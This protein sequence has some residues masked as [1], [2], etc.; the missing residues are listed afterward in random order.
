MDVG[1]G[2]FVFSHGLLD[3]A[4]EGRTTLAWKKVIPLVV[5][6]FIRLISVKAS[7]YHEHV[8]EYGV[9]W[10]FFFTL[11]VVNF[12]SQATL[13]RRIAPWQ[14]STSI[15]IAYHLLLKLGLES[16][17]MGPSERSGL[18]VANR[19]GVFSLFGYI[20]IY[21]AASQLGGEVLKPRNCFK[22]RL[23]LSYFDLVL[24]HFK[25][26]EIQK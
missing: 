10:N 8:T 22:D 9:H 13:L 7:G 26:Y 15:L 20:A 18:L 21:F 4:G 2:S 24:L 17:I 1:V 14:L 19:E 23:N 3:R 11:A 16:W 5:L 25:I 12:A 6:G